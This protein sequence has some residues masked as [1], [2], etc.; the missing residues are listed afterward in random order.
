MRDDVKTET[1]H[2][3]EVTYTLEHVE[4]QGY[5]LGYEY[6]NNQGGMNGDTIGVFPTEQE[7][8]EHLNRIGVVIGD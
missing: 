4:D 8:I 5:I 3:V 6:V 2:T 7:A 1:L